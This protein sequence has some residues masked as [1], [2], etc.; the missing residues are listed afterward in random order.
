MNKKRHVILGGKTKNIPEKLSKKYILKF[1]P[2]F[3]FMYLTI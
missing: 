1:W 3:Y 2:K